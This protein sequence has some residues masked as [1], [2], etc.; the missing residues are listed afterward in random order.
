MMFICLSSCLLLLRSWRLPFMI[1]FLKPILS[2]PLIQMFWNNMK[3]VNWKYVL[4]FVTCI[5]LLIHEVLFCAS[6]ADR[7]PYKEAR[8]RWEG[9]DWAYWRNHF[10]KGC[11]QWFSDM[12]DIMILVTN[13]L[14][15]LFYP[16]SKCY[17]FPCSH[18]VKLLSEMTVSC[19]ICRKVG[20]QHWETLWLK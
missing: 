2:F 14:Y 13:T 12:I 5:L 7:W 1:P 17:K 11:M 6:S 4:W 15:L 16:H 3:A 9:I 19:H 8:N 18:H 20:F 10:F